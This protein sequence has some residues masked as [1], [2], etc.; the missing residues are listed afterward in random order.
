MCSL[1]EHILDECP[2]AYRPLFYARY[3]DDT[4]ILFKHDHDAE[5]FLEF[6][7]SYHHNIT[8]T[9]EKEYDS[10]LAFLDILVT[11]DNGK[12]NTSVFRNKTFTGLGSNF[13]SFCFINFKLNSIYTLIHRALSLTSDW[14][15]FHQEIVF[16]QNYFTSNCFPVHVFHRILKKLLNQKFSNRPKYC[17]VPKLRLYATF[18][19]LY[20]D[21]FRRDFIKTVQKYIGAI[22]LKLIPKNPKSIASLFR[23]KDRLP[24]LMSSGV[25]YE[26]NC[27]KCNLGKYIGSTRRL[28]R[29]RADSHRGVSY[30]TGCQLANPESSNIR[31]HIIKCKTD[32]RYEDFKIIGNANNQQELLILETLNIKQRV[33]SLNCQTTAVPLYL[34]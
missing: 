22:D 9:T 1:E 19:F 31:S 10:K 29:V 21:N 33:P 26:Y 7:N 32:I 5:R 12:F 30:R 24:P 20:E 14:A 6:A 34:S 3:V 11:K 2:L 18:P 13:Y 23:F 27:P 28:L 8:F 25:V 17:E 15:L 4:F 16:L